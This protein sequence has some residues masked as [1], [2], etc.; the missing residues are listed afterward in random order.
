[1]TAARRY[2]TLN[3]YPRNSGYDE[4]AWRVSPADPAGVAS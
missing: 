2:L 3:A 1:L 4:A